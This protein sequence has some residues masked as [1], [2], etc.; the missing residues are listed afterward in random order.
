MS[1]KSLS[2]VTP[3]LRTVSDAMTKDGRREET[4]Q[5]AAM[6]ACTYNNEICFVR[7]DP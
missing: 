7:I 1:D 3:R 5:F 6:F 4:S 2:K